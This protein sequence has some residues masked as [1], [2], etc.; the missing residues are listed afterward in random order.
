M[1]PERIARPERRTH[2]WLRLGQA[3]PDLSDPIEDPVED[4]SMRWLELGMAGC[5]LGVVVLLSAL[6][7]SGDGAIRAAKILALGGA[8]FVSALVSFIR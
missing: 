2:R 4:R 3:V 1:H 7:P 5:A 6:D 8:L